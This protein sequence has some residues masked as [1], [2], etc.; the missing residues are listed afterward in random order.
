MQN[1]PN[2]PKTLKPT[3]SRLYWN[4]DFTGTLSLQ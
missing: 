3:S 2:I 1:F 4:P